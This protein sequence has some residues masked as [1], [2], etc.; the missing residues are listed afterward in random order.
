MVD[1]INTISNVV[2]SLILIV[3]LI[4]TDIHALYKKQ[5]GWSFVLTI[6]TVIQM[7]QLYLLL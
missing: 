6:L 5:Y 7:I 3:V 4:K 1:T 2:L